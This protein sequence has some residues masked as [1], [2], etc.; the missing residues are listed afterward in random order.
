M[1]AKVKPKVVYIFNGRLANLR[2]VLRLC[3]RNSVE[4]RIHER[5]SSKSKYSITYNVLPHNLKPF[6]ERVKSFWNDFEVGDARESIAREFYDK[7]KWGLDTDS[8]SFT[9]NQQLECLP[10][11]WDTSKRNIVMFNSSE[12]EFASIGDEYHSHPFKNQLEALRFLKEQVRGS[13]AI[14]IYLRIHP[15]LENIDIF[16]IQEL[17]SLVSS[18]FHVIEPSS[19]ISTYK[20]IDECDAVFTFGSTVGIEATY[21]GKPSVLI[22]SAFYEAFN[23]VYQVSSKVDLIEALYSYS[24]LKPIEGS[25]IYG[26]YKSEFGIRY[27]HYQP[28]S[29]F[30][31]LFQGKT[32]STANTQSKVAEQMRRLR[33][34]LNKYSP[35][36]S[37]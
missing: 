27:K 25:L 13:T 19:P 6:A 3:Q 2:V 28:Q 32:I 37:L 23:V 34:H 4:C 22:G 29:R 33:S 9:S 16:S 1:L 35:F 14:D 11:Q 15:N 36:A 24:E 31:G 17:Y 20:L 26:L 8:V 12:D 18:N 10:S 30:S 21:W 5:G 7:R